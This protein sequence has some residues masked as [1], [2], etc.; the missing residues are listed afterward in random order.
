MATK[1]LA[2]VFPDFEGLPLAYRKH[3]APL[4]TPPWRPLPP[5]TTI[6]SF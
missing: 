4:G 3:I 5:L 6:W 2:L 1:R